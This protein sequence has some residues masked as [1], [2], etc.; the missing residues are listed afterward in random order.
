MFSQTMTFV[1]AAGGD[2]DMAIE[3]NNDQG[4]ICTN[5]PVF[6]IDSKDKISMGLYFKI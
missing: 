6:T 3:D 4:I 1:K 5:Q 2:M